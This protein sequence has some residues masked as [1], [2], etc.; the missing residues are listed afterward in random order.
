MSASNAWAE[1][2]EVF[3]QTRTAFLQYENAKAELKTLMPEDAKEAAGHSIR[4]KRSKSGAISF[5]LLEVEAG[6][7]AVRESIGAIASAL[8]KAQSELTN[9]EKSLVAIRSPSPRDGDRTFRYASLSSG[10]DIV[11]K[12][13]GKSLN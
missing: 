9:P 1:F 8:A 4:A 6:Y 10:L 13:L 7:A 5:D 2:A 3:R 11:R 12:G